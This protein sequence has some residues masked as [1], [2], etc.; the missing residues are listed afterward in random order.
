MSINKQSK[1]KVV[2][3]KPRVLGV[4]VGTMFFQVAESSPDNPDDVSIKI[5]RNAFVELQNTEDMEDHLKRNGWQYIKDKDSFFVVGEDSIRV[6]NMFPG[7]ELRRPL[8]GGV[9]NQGEEKKF[10]VLTD[11]IRRSIGK[12][13]TEDS[14]VCTCVSSPSVDDSVDSSYHKGRLSGIFQ[15]LGWKVS[16]IEEG[17]AVILSE[18]PVSIEEGKEIP[19]S[20]IGISFGAGR[21]N[22]V[23]AYRGLQIPGLSMSAARSGDWIDSSV[24]KA[25]STNVSHVTRI[26]E[27]KLNLEEPNMEDDVEYALDIY[28]GEAI[29]FVFSKFADRFKAVKASSKQNENLFEYPVEIVLA[30]GTSSP[31]GFCKKVQNIV[32]ELSLPIEIRSIR[33][34]S[35]PRNAVVKGCNTQAART[36]MKQKEKKAKDMEDLIG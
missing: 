22:L 34:A 14:V 8:Q 28:Y 1:E 2:M 4:D 29:K 32:G 18:N 17:Y 35:D 21:V 9:L 24:A 27:K 36:F 19:Y 13:P 23:A 6:A 7:I 20:G 15:S 30:G 5:T 11:L 16:V 33:H 12:A 25:T 26:K 10:L 3:V 31:K